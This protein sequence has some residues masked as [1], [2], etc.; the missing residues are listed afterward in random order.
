MFRRLRGLLCLCHPDSIRVMPRLDSESK[1]TSTH[2]IE[3]QDD[4][5]F[6]QVLEIRRVVGMLRPLFF[7]DSLPS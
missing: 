2:Q 5:P 4:R 7:F 6:G 3:H 1:S